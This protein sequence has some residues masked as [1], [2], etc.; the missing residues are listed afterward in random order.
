[1]DSKIIPRTVTRKFA[2]KARIA[3]EF[4]FTSI[5]MLHEKIDPNPNPKLTSHQG[6]NLQSN[7]QP[8]QN[9][10][11][12]VEV[13]PTYRKSSQTTPKTE[14]H[15]SFTLTCSKRRFRTSTKLLTCEQ[16]PSSQAQKG[17][18]RGGSSRHFPQLRL[19]TIPL[20]PSRPSPTPWVR[21]GPSR[22][23]NHKKHGSGTILAFTVAVN[24]V[25]WPTLK[26]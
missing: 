16:R 22:Q 19:R 11:L 21:P 23:H 9:Q 6:E 12:L 26:R 13:P 24:Q 17:S 25:L 1:M 18:Q 4:P 10:N 14:I 20:S 2:L 15:P 8:T 5:G 7:L 3:L